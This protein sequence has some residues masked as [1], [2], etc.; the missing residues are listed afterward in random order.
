MLN[1]CIYCFFVN[2][3]RM[4]YELKKKPSTT[5][6]VYLK[7][8]NLFLK[9]II[10]ECVMIYKLSGFKYDFEKLLEQGFPQ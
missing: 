2:Q 4:K 9:F 10:Y 3:K 8:F 1:S 7:V 6:L 5:V